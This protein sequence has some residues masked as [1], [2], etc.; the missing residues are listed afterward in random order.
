M[1]LL[2]F[3][4]AQWATVVSYRYYVIT[5]KLDSRII[6]VHS[7][8]TSMA[9]SFTAGR[10]I[11]V[12]LLKKPAKVCSYVVLAMELD[13][14]VLGANPSLGNI[15]FQS[16][17]DKKI[18]NY[19]IIRKEPSYPHGR[20]DFLIQHNEL[21]RYIQVKSCFFRYKDYCI[22]P[23]AHLKDLLRL[24]QKPKSYQPMSPR[25]IKHLTHL[26]QMKGV[27]YFIGQRN[28]CNNFIINPREVQLTQALS[29]VD[30]KYF[31]STYWKDR[32]LFFDKII[33]I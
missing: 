31:V 18:L 26:G 13:G 14:V 21:V 12:Q 30:E 8:G 27:V 2:S 1:L 4:N 3:P 20:F 32:N 19:Q 15:I 11:L 7:P 28:D 16:L 5:A 22:F 6:F 9:D 17:V 25:A 23:L 10:S 24:E 33:R 29:K